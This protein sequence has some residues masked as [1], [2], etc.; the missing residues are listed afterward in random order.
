MADHCLGVVVGGI[1]GG[2]PA[3][4]PFRAFAARFFVRAFF[5]GDVALVGALAS[6]E[7]EDHSGNPAQIIV[8]SVGPLKPA[9]TSMCSPMRKNLSQVTAR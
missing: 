7:L 5:S 4:E 3:R 6:L 9:V 8:R 1:F 2:V